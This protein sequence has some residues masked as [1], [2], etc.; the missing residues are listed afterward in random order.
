MSLASAIEQK[1]QEQYRS[2]N[3]EKF[4]TALRELGVSY[5]VFNTMTNDLS[6]FTSEN[7]VCSCFR[8][9]IAK[10]RK[11]NWPTLG[12]SLDTIALQK[13]IEQLDTN[14]IDPIGFHKL[15]HAAGVISATV[16]LEARKIYYFGLD[17]QFFLEEF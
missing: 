1:L 13:A 12:N 9:D 14:Q 6:F 5:F 2:P 11:S 4:S 8:H 17:A 3:F 7:F 16:F 15:A 10:A